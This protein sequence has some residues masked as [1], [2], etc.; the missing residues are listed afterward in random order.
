MNSGH[1]REKDQEITLRITDL[2]R[3]GAGVG[4]DEQGQVVF[5]RWTAPG[6]LVRARIIGVKKRFIQGE[7]I[8]VLEPS[9]LRIEPRCKVFGRCGGCDWQHLAYDL[10]WKKK[11]EGVLHALSRTQVEYTGSWEEFPAKLQWSYRNRIQLRG[12]SGRVGFYGIRSRQLVPIERCEIA[13]EELN[14]KLPDI[15]ALGAKR[16]EPEYKV[17]LEVGQSGEVRD[18]WNARHAAGGFR[19]VHD[20]QNLLLQSWVRSHV[21]ASRVILDLYGGAGNL[22]LGLASKAQEV[23]CVDVSVPL[24]RSE[25]PRNYAFYRSSVLP[26]LNRKIREGMRLQGGVA[27]SDPPREGL[28][29][30]LT[31][32]A[33]A[34]EKLGVDTW[35]TVGCDP[36]SWARDLSRL[37][38]RGW[39]LERA[40]VLDLFPQ[41]H[42]VETMGCLSFPKGL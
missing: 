37:G 23:H 40:A 3:G 26:W 22:S 5:V 41:T 1:N 14:E 32:I 29:E 30:E 27:I 36:D 33:E 17:E 35:L 20:E 11:K 28:G 31:L 2:S 6:D 12:Q 24:E 8:E 19:Q 4:R 34:L 13:R 16:T 38:K 10:Q 25:I 18:F 9:S 7:L 21:P 39:L 42:H 15:R